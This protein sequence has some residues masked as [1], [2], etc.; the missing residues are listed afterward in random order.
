MPTFIIQLEGKE[1]YRTVENSRI[2]G[3]HAEM[4]IIEGVGHTIINNAQEQY[5][6]LI[7]EFLNNETAIPNQDRAI[8]CPLD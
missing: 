4:K 2:G 1:E 6:E 3:L 8:L 5:F 7:T